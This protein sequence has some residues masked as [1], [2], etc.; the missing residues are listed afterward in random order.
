MTGSSPLPIQTGGQG[1]TSLENPMGVKG[2]VTLLWLPGPG[3]PVGG[4]MGRHRCR[5][6]LPWGQTS[7]PRLLGQIRDRKMGW[8][9][10]QEGGTRKFLGIAGLC[11]RFRHPAT[12]G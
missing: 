5:P 1:H 3:L 11:L 6:A 9:G 2:L 4:Y 7:V 12:L 8:G 10:A